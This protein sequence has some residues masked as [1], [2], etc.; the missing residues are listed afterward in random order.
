MLIKLFKEKNKM[1]NKT[2]QILETLLAE[3]KRSETFGSVAIAKTEGHNF[4][5]ADIATAQEGST[6]FY[7]L[8]VIKQAN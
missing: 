4:A 5:S 6:E 1:M 8:I 2:G 7:K 3:L